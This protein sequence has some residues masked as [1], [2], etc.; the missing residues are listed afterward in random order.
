MNRYKIPQPL[1]L[2]KNIPVPAQFQT[3]QFH[4][5]LPLSPQ[6]ALS[7]LPAQ[8]PSPAYPPDHPE[9]LP[10]NLSL[11]PIQMK[12]LLLFHPEI[13]P[14]FLLEMRHLRQPRSLSQQRQQK[15][16]PKHLLSFFFSCPS[17]PFPCFNYKDYAAGAQKKYKQ[18]FYS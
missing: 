1:L 2:Q 18:D 13:L 3:R 5:L 6:N 8:N 17:A 12:V 4:A 16:L 10:K 15:M 7:P 11:L 14:A 9:H